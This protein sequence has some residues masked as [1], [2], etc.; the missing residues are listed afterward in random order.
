MKTRLHGA[1]YSPFV[2]TARLALELADEPYDLVPVDV[3]AK[4]T[5]TPEHLVLH[6][7]GKIPVLEHGDHRVIETLA[8]LDYVDQ[9]MK[10]GSVLPTAPASRARSLAIASACFAYGYAPIVHQVFGP[11]VMAEKQGSIPQP[12]VVEEGLL[13]AAAFLEAMDKLVEPGPF[14]VT[15]R[16]T[17]ADIALAPLLDLLGAHDGG[18]KLIEKTD[19]IRPWWSEF[20]QEVAVRKTRPA[21]I[22]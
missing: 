8:I 9:A 11:G 6:P 3:F 21:V 4:H 17:A 7:F 2:R 22:A 14:L 20:A 12:E 1:D 13:A 15:E 19:R 10:P 18:A 5:R 16:P